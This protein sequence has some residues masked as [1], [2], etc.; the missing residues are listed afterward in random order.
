M[1]QINIYG[2]GKVG[3]KYID[4]CFAKGISDLTLVDS[5]N[6]LWGSQYK[7]LTI[8]NPTDISWQECE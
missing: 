1:K 6:K 2:I 7:G 3:K 4:D 8:H 5:N